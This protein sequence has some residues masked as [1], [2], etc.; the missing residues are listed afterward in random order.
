MSLKSKWSS[1]TGKQKQIAVLGS[2]GGLGLLILITA[3]MRD[4]NNGVLRKP[5]KNTETQVLTPATRNMNEERMAAEIQALR[6]QMEADRRERVTQQPGQ[7]VQEKGL[8]E[9]EVNRKIADALQAAEEARAAKTTSERETVNLG[10]PLADGNRGDGKVTLPSETVPTEEEQDDEP[11]SAFQSTSAVKKA[12]TGTSKKN[13]DADDE[14]KTYLPPGSTLSVA[15]L[16]GVNAPT[17]TNNDSKDPLPVLMQV[18]GTAIL[19]NGYRSDLSNCFV[20][21]STFGQYMDARAMMRTKTISCIRND[22]KAVEANIQGTVFGEDGKPGFQGRLV[23]KTGKVISQLLKVG[24][25]ETM[26]NIATGVANGININTGSSSSTS[27]ST[28]I[29]LGG[30][31]GQAASK[32]ASKTFDRIADIYSSYGTQ[33][34]PV[35]EV[36]PL[37]TGEIILTQG[38]FLHI[39]HDTKKGRK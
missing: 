3:A 29:N 34:I 20:L 9:D 15:L 32:A 17:N 8:S 24:A 14:S 25:M 13:S 23:S 16:S 26:A 37:R 10:A 2:V 7:G 22:G 1:M 28:Q 39:V 33:A 36:E 4:Y 27:T 6:Q 19:P 11:K 38:V 30:V 5:E 12:A 35:V 31:S 18:R 21:A